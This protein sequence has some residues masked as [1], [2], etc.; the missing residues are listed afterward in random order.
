MLVC[1]ININ[2]KHIG[3]VKVAKIIS[4]FNNKGGVSKTTTTF[5]LSWILAESGKKVLMV[6]TDPQCNLTGLCLSLSG[7]DNFEDFYLK[8]NIDNIKSALDPVFEGQ[9]QEL[10]PAKCYNF[11]LNKNLF[12]LPGHI[13]FSEFDAPINI[14]QELTGTLKLAQNIPGAISHLLRITAKENNFDYILIDMSPSV[15]ATNAN[16]LMQ[17]DFFIVPCSPD[18]F[19]HMAVNSLCK[20][21]P[22]WNNIYE[23]IKTHPIFRESIY[24]FPNTSPKFIGTILQRYRPRNG[25]A[26]SSFQA[27]INKINDNVNK[28]LVPI[29]D[30]NKMIIDKSKFAMASTPEEPYNIINIS[31]FN[32]LIA[33]SQKYNVPIFSL[34]KEQIGQQGKVLENMEESRKAFYK[35]FQKLGDIVLQL[36]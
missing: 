12:L 18:Y 11:P 34:T 2:T 9:P 28:N 10:K 7:T 6:D 27:W 21:L 35:T 29:L 1:R 31:D 13:E 36:T 8:S 24:K 14:A 16:V 32:S 23:G 20:I 17:S 30:K 22:N 3:G 5:N 4:L 25:G 15:S 26:A 19:C 33:Q